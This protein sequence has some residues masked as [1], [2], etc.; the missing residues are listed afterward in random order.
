MDRFR[1]LTQLV[2][3]EPKIE[4]VKLLAF[5]FRSVIPDP[6][7][8]HLHSVFLTVHYHF[9]FPFILVLPGFARCHRWSRD[10]ER[11]VF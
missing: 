9:F 8:L 2:S 4:R 5:F 7:L 11:K 3:K 6:Y 10:T 1:I